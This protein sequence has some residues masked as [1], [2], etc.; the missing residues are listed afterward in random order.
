V[1]SY[2]PVITYAPSPLPIPKVEGDIHVLD[3]SKMKEELS[4]LVCGVSHLLFHSKF[5]HNPHNKVM[6]PYQNFGVKN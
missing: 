2:P 6:A 5:S 1:Q 3:S 4:V